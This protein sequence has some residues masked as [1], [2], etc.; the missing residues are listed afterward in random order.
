MLIVISPAKTLDYSPLNTAI[1][2]SE[3]S[4]IGKTESLVKEMRNYDP[5][6]ISSLMKISENLGF[7]NFER[8]Q[9]WK[10]DS[11]PGPESKQSAFA[12]KGDVYKGLDIASLDKG[13]INYAQ[14]YLRILSGLY[15]LLKPL[16][17]IAPYRLEMGTK[18]NIG[19]SKNLY[20][21]WTSDLTSAIN[22][23]LKIQKTKIL[24]NLASNEYF[25]A[26][27]QDK[28][29]AE[30]ISPVFKDYKNGDYKII[31]FH[32]KKARGLMTRFILSNSLKDPKDIEK[33][34]YEGYK[35]SEK[36]S[37]DNTPVFLRNL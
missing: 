1:G 6:M 24:V 4:F 14:N 12:F 20:E 10:Q 7:L 28:L 26:L 35:F 32:A 18:L 34:D 37:K 36:L 30:V 11:S 33:F 29:E 5:E 16:D 9:S 21:Y 3:P 25:S 23:D 31:S 2:F 22:K 13:S 15:G 27:D 19:D 17:L 8:F